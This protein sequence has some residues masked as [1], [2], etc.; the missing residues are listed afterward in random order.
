MYLVILIYMISDYT[1]SGS[2]TSRFTFDSLTGLMDF[3]MLWIA[4]HVRR[5]KK[6]LEKETIR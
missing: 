1:H 6:T 3:E 2:E 4:F 5:R